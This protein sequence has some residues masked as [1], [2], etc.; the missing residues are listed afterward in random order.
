MLLVSCSDAW[1]DSFADLSIGVSGEWRDWKDA[2]WS[3]QQ[4][5]GREF[6]RNG[7]SRRRWMRNWRQNAGRVTYKELCVSRENSRSNVYSSTKPQSGALWPPNLVEIVI[8]VAVRLVVGNVSSVRQVD[9]VE[10]TWEGKMLLLNV[11]PIVGARLSNEWI[12]SI[13]SYLLL[14][15]CLTQTLVPSLWAIIDVANLREIQYAQLGLDLSP[16]ARRLVIIER[17]R[18]F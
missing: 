17:V 6:R 16:G 3:D 11:A 7:G 9:V 12:E 4:P 1:Y 15:S 14:S 5:Y 8:L 18:S 10:G 13:N 2:R